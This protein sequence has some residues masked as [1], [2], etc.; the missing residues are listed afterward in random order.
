MRPR[1]PRHLRIA[2]HTELISLIV[3]LANVFTVHLK[4]VSSLM[5]PTHGCAYLFVVIATWRLEDAPTV[6]KVLA[7]VP[8]AGGLLA[9]RRLAPADPDPAQPKE[10]IQS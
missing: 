4:P 6:A 8:G 5:G 10:V 2:A 3:M 7:V 9:L 1:S